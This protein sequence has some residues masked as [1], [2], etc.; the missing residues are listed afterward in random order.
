MMFI[1]QAEYFRVNNLHSALPCKKELKQTRVK[2]YAVSL[3]DSLL[4]LLG[5]I[6]P[7]T[8]LIF[9]F[10]LDRHCLV[11]TE[12]VTVSELLFTYQ[13]FS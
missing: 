6:N 3:S 8:V 11:N 7:G 5:Y 12:I 4:R 13:L 9:D 1:F 2:L 10:D